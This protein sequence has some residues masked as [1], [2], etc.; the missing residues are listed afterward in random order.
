VAYT[1]EMH[2]NVMDTR[3]V[4]RNFQEEEMLKPVVCLKGR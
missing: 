2:F 1:S 4:V 3:V